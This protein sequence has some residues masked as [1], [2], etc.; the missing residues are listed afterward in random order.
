MIAMD[1]ASKKKKLRKYIWLKEKRKPPNKWA[2]F[3]YP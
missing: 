1:L 2:A 3:P